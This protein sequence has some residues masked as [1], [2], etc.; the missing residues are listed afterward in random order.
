[1][2]VYYE[3]SGGY[4]DEEEFDLLP[5]DGMDQQLWMREEVIDFQD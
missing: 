3:D 2:A 4:R 1:M 5:D